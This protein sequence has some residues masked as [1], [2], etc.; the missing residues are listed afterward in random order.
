ML[1]HNEQN[2]LIQKIQDFFYNTLVTKLI[3]DE[4]VNNANLNS[5]INSKIVQ[6]ILGI[7]ADSKGKTD[8]I[9]LPNGITITLQNC[10]TIYLPFFQ[11][12]SKANTNPDLD[13]NELKQ[14]A[15]K[16]IRLNTFENIINSLKEFVLEAK[17]L[18]KVV[19]FD[20]ENITPH[21]IRETFY[22]EMVIQAF[23]A[24]ENDWI[25]QE[26]LNAQESFIYFA[27]SALTIIEA[28]YQSKDADGICLRNNKLLTTQN[29]PQEENFPQLFMPILEKKALFNTLLGDEIKLVKQ[30]CLSK[31]RPLPK[32]LEEL[33]AS[34]KQAVMDCA[35]V[36]NRIASQISQ[37][38]VF[39]KV[40]GNVLDIFGGNEYEEDANRLRI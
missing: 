20:R 4:T 36:I 7:L 11:I 27:L 40:F 3:K 18:K 14:L 25:T 28:L 10:P 32:E 12:L 37:R 9:V 31:D 34:K 29:C 33:E 1:S 22:N 16:V 8:A 2:T 13:L 15:D 24:V 26:E 23:A 35:T 17:G 21:L 6:I 38:D 19:S 30:L 39:K 5:K